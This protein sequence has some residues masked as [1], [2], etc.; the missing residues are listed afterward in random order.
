MAKY[1][2]NEE[3]SEELRKDICP[4]TTA[5]NAI[6]GRWKIVILWQLSQKDIIRFNEF[7]R[8]IPGISKKILRS[9]LEELE[10]EKLIYRKVYDEV[11][12][13]VEY[14]LSESGKAFIP[15]LEKMKDW[16]QLLLNEKIENNK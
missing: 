12:L 6:S 10:N 11:P 16:G 1:K 8:L 5:Q 3:L 2:F 4:I 7:Q 15:V 13:K 9:Q 14:F